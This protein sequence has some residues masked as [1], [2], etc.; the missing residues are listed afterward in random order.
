MK[1]LFSLIMAVLPVSSGNSK[2]KN[3]A[4]K[5]GKTRQLTVPSGRGYYD[6]NGLTMY[7]EIHGE[8]RPLV[9]VHGAGSTIQTTFGRILPE[10]SRH[11]QVIA[12]EL[13]GHG[14]TPDVDRPESF[15]QDAEDVAGLLHNLEITNA[16]FFG[17]S[18]GGNAV[19]QIAIRHPELVG[20][21]I[22]GST[23]FKRDAFSPE[24]WE[25]LMQGT[26]NDMPQALKDAY[27][28][29]APDPRNLIKMFEKDRQR[30]L[31]FA[32]WDEG[33]IRSIP[34]PALIIIGDQDVVRP[35]HAVGMFRLIP[36]CR[37]AI[38]PGGHGGYLGEIETL[39]DDDA[40]EVI[41]TATLVEKF[42][43]E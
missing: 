19:M 28:K 36:G 6:V 27:E 11:R 33:D 31:E 26:L 24:F 25:G 22:L 15:E 39:R 5:T 14:R 16:D 32:D 43:R 17:F 41:F 7:Y 12:V 20:K 23:F 13:Q 21:I 18:N 42:L 2:T 37:L 4:G 3:S 38:I 9:L 35:E 29:V 34:A 10:L 1:K 8:D 30:M 40:S